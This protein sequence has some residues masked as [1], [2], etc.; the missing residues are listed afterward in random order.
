MPRKKVYV[1]DLDKTILD[2]LEGC[3]DGVRKKS[4]LVNS[5]NILD[6]I[7]CINEFKK[8]VK[9]VVDND[10]GFV[11]IA[12]MSDEGM[13]AKAT[14]LQPLD[15]ED[16]WIAGPKLVSDHVLQAIFASSTESKYRDAIFIEAF[17][18]NK[19]K[20]HLPFK[21]QHIENILVRISEKFNIPKEDIIAKLFD[22]NWENVNYV[23]P[24][25]TTVCVTPENSDEEGECVVD[26]EIAS[27]DDS[28]PV[29]H[30]GVLINNNDPSQ[31]LTTVLKAELEKLQALLKKKTLF[32]DAR[33]RLTQ[34]CGE[35]INVAPPPAERQILTASC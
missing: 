23:N 31:S 1:F 8:F 2:A 18:P 16:A 24:P 25:A 12:T 3:Y 32:F 5:Q 19:E 21:R 13:I 22:D 10:L 4:W 33:S 34:S 15:V 27:D 26:V 20:K 9:T 17:K 28:L 14:E 30:K 6:S 7:R 29:K 35:E 11:A